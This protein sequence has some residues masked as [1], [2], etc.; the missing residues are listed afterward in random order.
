LAVFLASGL[1]DFALVLAFLCSFLLMPLRKLVF[2]GLFFKFQF[3]APHAIFG[4]P[5]TL[6]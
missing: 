4:E 5:D 1:S 6:G 2:D 3:S